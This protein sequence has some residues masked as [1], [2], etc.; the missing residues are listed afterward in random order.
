MNFE[1]INI[2]RA[3]TELEIQQ[4]I[5]NIPVPIPTELDY[6]P[7]GIDEEY[8]TVASALADGIRNIH[9]IGDT[10]EEITSIT[11]TTSIYISVLPNVT[12]NMN[13]LRFVLNNASRLFISGSGGGRMIIGNEAAVTT[14][15]FQGTNAQVVIQNIRITKQDGLSSLIDIGD[16]TSIKLFNC[17]IVN[18]VNGWRVLYTQSKVSVVQNCIFDGP[19]TYGPVASGMFVQNT[20]G[21]LIIRN[22]S[23]RFTNA[24]D[25]NF[26]FIVA[27]SFPTDISDNFFNFVGATG[28]CSF[29]MAGRNKVIS[30]NTF[31]TA[32]MTLSLSIAGGG[33]MTIRNQVLHSIVDVVMATITNLLLDNC[34]ILNAV[35]L[36]IFV[37][38]TIQNCTFLNNV[39]TPNGSQMQFIGNTV[40]GTMTLQNIVPMIIIGNFFRAGIPAVGPSAADVIANNVA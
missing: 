11:V 20:G 21:S 19:G 31:V 26:I 28:I 23:F 17:N 1:V 4:A 5:D 34:R 39:T 30:N 27:G 12:W 36:G 24:A 2:N 33:S 18:T 10:D 25:F 3:L 6:T 16:D 22:N 40:T 37:D 8:T 29:N 7:I 13:E 38:S 14:P 32:G 35:T 9:V 15:T